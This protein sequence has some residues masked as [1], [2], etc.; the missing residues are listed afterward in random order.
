[1]YIDS[2]GI[3]LLELLMGTRVSFNSYKVDKEP[4]AEEEL[5]LIGLLRMLKGKLGKGGSDTLINGIVD[6][7]LNGQF[8]HTQAAVMM[9]IAKSCLEEESYKRPTMNSVLEMLSSLNHDDE[10][11]S[12]THRL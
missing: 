9:R 8:N 7:R 3:V 2:Y 10:H 11:A 12:A 4:A 6:E 5:E 1:M